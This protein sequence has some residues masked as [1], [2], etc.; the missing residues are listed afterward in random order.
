MVAAGSDLHPLMPRQKAPP[1]RLPLAG[2]G[3]YDLKR[4][5]PSLMS[6]IVFFRGLHCMQC[7]DYITELDSMLPEFERR[8]INVVAA[9]GDTRERGEATP[10]T[11]GL[12]RL[13]LAFGLTPRQARDWGLFLTHG[14][15]R[16]EGMQEPAWYSEPGLFL[17]E[18][19]GAL[20]FTAVQNMPFARP[21]FEDII[22][23]FEFMFARGYFIDKPCPAR[24]EIVTLAEIAPPDPQ[25]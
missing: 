5:Q 19:G 24:G 3:D 17:V 12:S 8:G 13:R 1:L 14:R 2:G 25:T 6:M 23:G 21:R 7:R 10:S 18:P 15:P 11:W 9:S 4:E 16:A 20:F 22:A